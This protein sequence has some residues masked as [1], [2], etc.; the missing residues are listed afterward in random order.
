MCQIVKL[1]IGDIVLKQ[2]QKFVKVKNGTPFKSSFFFCFILIHHLS[3]VEHGVMIWECV[4]RKVK[5]NVMVHFLSPII[6]FTM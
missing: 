5:L 3:N 1:M 2:F 6:L 4:V